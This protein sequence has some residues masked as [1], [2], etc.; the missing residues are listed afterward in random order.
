MEYKE[1]VEV[2]YSEPIVTAL[3]GFAVLPGRES[4]TIG[5]EIFH[6]GAILGLTVESL[7]EDSQRQSL[8]FDRASRFENLFR[9]LFLDR[10]DAV[11]CNLAVARHVL[12][13]LGRDPAAIAW[14]R[15][16]PKFTASFNVSSPR[17]ELIED[18]DLWLRANA[19][20]V[21]DL[22]K[23]YDLLD[24]ETREWGTEDDGT[25]G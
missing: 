1:G 25:G 24:D 8:T 4:E 19:D 10:I 15:S 5:D 7:L 3:D 6:I 13:G 2:H 20:R 11:Y 14:N 16:L 22:K 18:L 9:A 17:R 21:R 12:D 23:K